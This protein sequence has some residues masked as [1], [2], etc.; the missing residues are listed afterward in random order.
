M[1][2]RIVVLGGA[3]FLASKF[4]EYSKFDQSELFFFSQTKGY[5]AEKLETVSKLLNSVSPTHILN[6]CAFTNVDGCEKTP[7]F[8]C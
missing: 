1:P 5:Q 7:S 2:I 6:F 4:K 8:S 3:G